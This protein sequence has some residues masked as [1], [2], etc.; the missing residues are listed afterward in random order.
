MFTTY[1]I[2]DVHA[3]HLSCMRNVNVPDQFVKA[4]RSTANGKAMMELN[5]G[6]YTNIGLH[7]FSLD[8]QSPTL[9]FELLF[10]NMKFRKV[11]CMKMYMV[12]KNMVASGATT[13]GHMLHDKVIEISSQLNQAN[14]CTALG[15]YGHA[16]MKRLEQET[17]EKCVALA[18]IPMGNTDLVSEEIEQPLFLNVILQV[19]DFST[20]SDNNLDILFD[21]VPIV[22]MLKTS[23]IDWL[24]IVPCLLT[25]GDSTPTVITWLS[26]Q[27]A[28][29][30]SSSKYASPLGNFSTATMELLSHIVLEECEC[31]GSC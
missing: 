8:S 17:N 24:L 19:L 18:I 31:M 12:A 3:S 5:M 21:D 29:S 7:D 2:K 30:Q 27:K 15:N 6:L 23:A 25:N 4:I 16:E 9:G 10:A 28:H 14:A 26:K 22:G 13:Q 20:Y 11:L 1:G